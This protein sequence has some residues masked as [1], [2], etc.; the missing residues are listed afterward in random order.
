MFQY[1]LCAFATHDNGAMLGTVYQMC[2]VALV[3]EKV[4]LYDGALRFCGLALE[5]DL[6][7]AGAPFTKAGDDDSVHPRPRA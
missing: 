5:T 2:W 3:H 6:R 7:K 1:A 4:G